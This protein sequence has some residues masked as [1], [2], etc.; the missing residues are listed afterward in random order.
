MIPTG[1][2][3]DQRDA[4]PQPRGQR[5]PPH[6]GLIPV[7]KNPATPRPAP[8]R[9]SRGFALLITITLLAFLVLLLVSL[10]SLTRVETQVADNNQRLS[11]A[12]QNAL[13]ALNIALG[14]LQKHT[15]LDQRVTARADVIKPST[16]TWS[17]S[18][19][20]DTALA[21]DKSGIDAYW[22]GTKRNR[23]WIG[24]WKNSNSTAFNANNPAASNPSPS[25]QSWLVSG[26]ENAATGDT[27]KPVDVVTGLSATS[28]ALDKLTDANGKPHR[29]LVKASAG[30]TDNASLD[31]AVTAP[32]IE[33]TSTT[34]PGTNGAATP[35]G[36]YAWWVGDEGVKARANLVDPYAAAGTTEA[37]RTRLQSAQRPAI[38]A[39]TT[40]GT[41][42]LSSYPVNT[43]TLLKILTPAQLGT[44]STDATF[45]TELKTRFH[46]LSVTSR[47]VLADTKNGGLKSDLSYILG[48][49]TQANFLTALRA[50]YGGNTVAPLAT[51]ASSL[52]ANPILT[53]TST[54]LAALP[55]GFAST[56][57]KNTA[58][59]EQLW[60]FANQGSSFN[61]SGQ[62]TPRR[63]TAVQHGLYP[64]AIQVKMFY[65]L[66]FGDGTGSASVN[67]TDTLWVDSIPVVLLANPYSVPLAAAD[68]H[69]RISI[70]RR[71]TN[72][73]VPELIFSSDATA[74]SSSWPSAYPSGSEPAYAGDTTFILRTTGMAA[75]E[76]QIF[77][78]DPSPAVNPTIDGEDR[79]L[80]A[81][82]AS[83][84]PVV[85][86]ND[87]D[88]VPALTYNTGK[89]LPATNTHA[90]L[91]LADG[92]IITHLYMDYIASPAQRDRRLIQ[93][94]T[95]QQD[96]SEYVG[97]ERTLFVVDPMSEG[98]RQGGG[99]MLV[100][101]QPPTTTHPD[102]LFTYQQAPF[103]QVNY[104]A[105]LVS[106]MGGGSSHPLQWARRFDKNGSTGSA[107][108]SPNSWIE[109]NLMRPS[110]ST[111]TSRWG[112]V[113]IG[114]GGSQTQPPASIGSSSVGFTNFLYDIPR[115]GHPLSSLG[116]FQQ[117]NTAGYV[118]DTV[119]QIPSVMNSWQTNYPIS[120][121]YPQPRVA[122]DQLMLSNATYRDHFDGSYLWNDLFWDRFYF[123]TYPQTGSFDFASEK[124]I[125]SRYRPFRDQSV[126]AWDDEASFRGDGNAATAAN[127]RVASQNLLAEGA[128]NIN[129]TSV[130][131]WK[132]VFSSLKKIPVGTES[133]PSAP[134]VRTLVPTA[135]S[136]DAAT[137]TSPNSWSGFR[138]LSRTEIQSLAEEMAMQIRKRGPFLSLS[139]FVNRRLVDSGS[140]SLGLGLSGA[141]QAA[142][143]RV[144]NLND[145]L[146]VA[147]RSVQSASTDN[148]LAENGY[149]LPSALAG[150][151][152]YLLQ[153][154][155]LSAL[156]PTLA[157]RSDTFTIRTYGDAVNPTTGEVTGRAWCEAVVQRTPDYVVPKNGS[158]GDAPAD[159]ATDATNLAFGR[160]YQI[161]SFRWLS[162]DDI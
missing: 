16:V 45:P 40:S 54:P 48:Q 95:A 47:G 115:P 17:T 68:Y 15:G 134:F 133:T 151:P 20:P 125:N 13:M 41:D 22:Q 52:S 34:V 157:A 64:L 116:Q 120:N 93:Y 132:A 101:N 3:P 71:T 119:F 81:D 145:H 110:G 5:H 144:V 154:D 160:R 150:F 148:G 90:A 146:A 55:S 153:G 26:N 94:I 141:L 7:S 69:L 147:F 35:V 112:I 113:N 70:L 136:S 130:E 30:V 152:G 50:N 121:S 36:H 86:K 104:R 82:S 105:L 59:W 57:F 122:R 109:A 39:M 129:S 100:I 143:D 24:A 79:I 67:H 73:N 131:A 25:L 76:A 6:L 99:T 140:D 103:L 1:L 128:F 155:M 49:S 85:M 46:D 72:T 102:T 139:E 18:A 58:T 98:I 51:T 137:G 43:D 161:V 138:D 78:I 21:A 123:S 19:A 108:T 33:I 142:L 4:S 88:P 156:G 23:H 149:I 10:A 84:A 135:G 42:G 162:P 97:S 87:F 29:L 106:F 38:E 118:P 12:R 11:Q 107:G 111:T 126:V 83:T 114:E 61:S 32:E 62:A 60:S 96:L 8:V 74:A 31:R 77:T 56:F 9:S 127:A 27:F 117:F 28:T 63:H 159:T 124:L 92:A 158:A 89:T 75:G 66:R 14:Q 37:N 65:R 91:R 2:E 80:V 53:P 44:L